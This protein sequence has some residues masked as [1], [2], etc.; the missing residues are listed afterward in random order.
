M[1][2]LKHGLLLFIYHVFTSVLKSAEQWA[3]TFTTD[4]CHNFSDIFGTEQRADYRVN[5]LL[6]CNNRWLLPHNNL[7][8]RNARIRVI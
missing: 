3:H 4:F 1:R 8:A 6:F 2:P 7:G 5:L